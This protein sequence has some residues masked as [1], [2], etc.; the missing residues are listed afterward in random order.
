MNNQKNKSITCEELWY[1][2]YFKIND[3]KFW[4]EVNYQDD[5]M[6]FYDKY[7]LYIYLVL[8]IFGFIVLTY[9]IRSFV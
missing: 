2:I 8:W 9:F 4:Y 5:L 7:K 3:I 6:K 1:K